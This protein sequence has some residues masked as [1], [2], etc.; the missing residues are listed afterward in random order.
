MIT[1]PSLITEQDSQVGH[2]YPLRQYL[3]VPTRTHLLIG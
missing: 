3:G 1:L 2:N